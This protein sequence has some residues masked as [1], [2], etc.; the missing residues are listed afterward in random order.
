MNAFIERY[1]GL[2]ELIEEFEHVTMAAEDEER[3]ALAYFKK[4]RKLREDADRVKNE[5][6]EP[7][8]LQDTLEGHNVKSLISS[9]M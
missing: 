6:D 2:D 4:Q 8:F 1:P 3:P 7:L 9:Q 5:E